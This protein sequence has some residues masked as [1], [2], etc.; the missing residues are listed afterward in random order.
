MISTQ[1]SFDRICGVPYTAL[2]IASVSVVQMYGLLNGFLRLK[3]ICVQKDKH[4]I[5]KRKETKDYGTKQLIEGIH[6]IGDKVVII[7]DIISSGSSI[8]ETALVGKRWFL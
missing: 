7:E 6:N 4:M 2:P 1:I 3:C 8:L 5:T